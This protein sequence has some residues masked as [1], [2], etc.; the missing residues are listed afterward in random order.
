MGTIFWV[1][2]HISG[3]I[4]VLVLALALSAGLYMLSMLAEE[5][6]KITGQVLKYSLAAIAIVQILLWIDG[7]PAYESMVE[8]CTLVAYGS[9][10][11]RFPYIDVVSIESVCAVIGFFATNIV[12]LRFFLKGSDDALSV[13][14]FFVVIVWAIPCGLVASLTI[15]E[16]SLP[17][18]QPAQS[19]PMPGGGEKRKSS[20]RVAYDFLWEQID[21]MTSGLW[22]LLHTLKLVKEKRQT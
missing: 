21:K 8:L 19:L 9:M 13:L 7:L 1:F 2:S 6:P 3:Y 18:T 14:G 17:S 11:R 4:S 16:Y 12:W 20:F 10:L 22:G 5:F 15:N